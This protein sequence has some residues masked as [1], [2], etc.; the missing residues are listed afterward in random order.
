MIDFAPTRH[1][2]QKYILIFKQFVY[3]SINNRILF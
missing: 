1:I 3:K 2:S